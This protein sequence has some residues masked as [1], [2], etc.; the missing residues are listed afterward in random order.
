MSGKKPTDGEAADAAVSAERRRA[1]VRARTRQ[2]A[3]RTIEVRTTH[4]RLLVCPVGESLYG[5]PLRDVARVRPF[6]RRGLA[7]A[8]EPAALGL[9]VDSGEIRPALDL[10]VLLGQGSG[11]VAGGWLLVLAPPHR[12]ALRV[13]E[14]PVAAEVEPVDGAPDRARIVGGEHQDKILARLSAGDL[15]AS[16]ANPTLGAFAS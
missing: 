4:E 7:P 10:A 1:I 11:S 2:L 9:V 5:L 14:M 12:A 15:L 3:A 8:Q 16:Y 13:E 6:D